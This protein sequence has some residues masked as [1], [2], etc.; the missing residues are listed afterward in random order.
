[1]GNVF[2]VSYLHVFHKINS[3]NLSIEINFK[4]PVHLHN[5]P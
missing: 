1:M 5:I 2:T 3:N 4:I